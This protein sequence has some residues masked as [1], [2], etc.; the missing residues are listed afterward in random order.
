MNNPS[1]AA[2]PG[3]GNAANGTDIELVPARENPELQ[4]GSRRRGKKKVQRGLKICKYRF[5]KDEDGVG[6]QGEILTLKLNMGKIS[7]THKRIGSLVVKAPHW[8]TGGPGFKPQPVHL[9]H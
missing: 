7:L 4:L 5:D 1:P 9:F 8:H 6:I 3:V 2:I